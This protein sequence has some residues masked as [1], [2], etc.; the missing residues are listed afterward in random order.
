MLRSLQKRK[1]WNTNIRKCCLWV[2]TD[3]I[4]C[5]IGF[6][7]GLNYTED[8]KAHKQMSG[9]SK[10]CKG[11]LP[12]NTPVLSIPSSD[13]L[14]PHLC[15]QLVLPEHLQGEER[16]QWRSK[17][18]FCLSQ[19]KWMQRCSSHLGHFAEFLML[20]L[21]PSIICTAKRK[22]KDLNCK[23]EIERFGFV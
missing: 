11:F 2:L 1:K 23:E 5:L 20:W 19:A 15:C 10:K 16:S 17:S 22:F 9:V 18:K 4:Y 14:F 21:I 7:D 3:P 13:L 6:P 8:N 12:G